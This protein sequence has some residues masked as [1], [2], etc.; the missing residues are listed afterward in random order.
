MIR[1]TSRHEPLRGIDPH[2]LADIMDDPAA[3]VPQ[4]SAP[5]GE[6]TSPLT[7]REWEEC[8]A[9]LESLIRRGAVERTPGGLRTAAAPGLVTLIPGCLR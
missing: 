6:R 2:V 7:P 5:Q 9:A 4:P 8:R 1:V 3:V